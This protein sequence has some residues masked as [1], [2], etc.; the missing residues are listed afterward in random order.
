MFPTGWKV[1]EGL[2]CFLH[3]QEWRRPGWLWYSFKKGI[4][5]LLHNFML[6]NFLINFTLIYWFFLL[7]WNG[8]CGWYICCLLVKVF[9][10]LCQNWILHVLFFWWIITYFESRLIQFLIWPFPGLDG[11]M[12]ANYCE[13]LGSILGVHVRF[14]VDKVAL[15]QIF[16]K[17]LWFTHANHHSTIVL[18]S[19][20]TP[21]DMFDSLDQV[22]HYNILGL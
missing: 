7:P 22:T 13:S 10:I 17:I 1:A 16:F 11:Y 4:I 3:R 8:R 5:C 20:I 14:V 2:C 15:E 19:S 21:P 12:L 6:L 9:K 18:Y